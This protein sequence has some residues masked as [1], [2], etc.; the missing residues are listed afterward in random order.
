[1]GT[2]SKQ[3]FEKEIIYLM[4]IVLDTNI[5]ISALFWNGLPKKIF[6]EIQKHHTLCF[7]KET[8]LELEQTFNYPK[9]KPR[10]YRLSFT[11]EEFTHSLIKDALIIDIS[12]KPMQIIK[13][14]PDDNKFLACAFKSRADCIIS[15]DKHL[16]KI[17]KFQN[18][19]I[20][21]TKQFLQ[22][23]L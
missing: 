11:I 19:P 6:N 4:R 7:C 1:M 23:Y 22:K 16:L 15:G 20:L 3:K 21:T 2:P 8:L 9:F 12:E 13:E 10:I 14:H 17:K 18:I 5:I